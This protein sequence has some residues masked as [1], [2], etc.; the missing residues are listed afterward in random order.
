[1]QVGDSRLA[2]LGGQ[3]VL[4]FGLKNELAVLQNMV[5]ADVFLRALLRF[6][7]VRLRRLSDFSRGVLAAC[8]GEM[9]SH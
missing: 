5:R 1:L 2:S 3:S 6:R 4:H 7:A 8:G 9:G